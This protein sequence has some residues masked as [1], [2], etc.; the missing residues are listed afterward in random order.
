MTHASTP[1]S[2]L[3]GVATGLSIAAIKTRVEEWSA[4]RETS[5]TFLMEA[6]KRFEN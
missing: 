2:I 6:A 4:K 3:A 1:L 5:L